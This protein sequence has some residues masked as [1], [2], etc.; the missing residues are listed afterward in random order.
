MPSVVQEISKD[1]NKLSDAEKDE[2]PLG[3]V[4]GDSRQLKKRKLFSDS[5]AQRFVSDRNEIKAEIKKNV[6][7]LL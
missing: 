5:Q 4:E 2:Y 6:F 7:S 1:W 3:L